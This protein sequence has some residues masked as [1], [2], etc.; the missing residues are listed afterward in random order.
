MTGDRSVDVDVV[1]APW[2]SARLPDSDRIARLT[3]VALDPG[4][5]H[6]SGSAVNPEKRIAERLARSV[7][8]AL[9]STP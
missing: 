3:E 9:E 6:A 8:H 7:R 4:A 2:S 1:I 5:H